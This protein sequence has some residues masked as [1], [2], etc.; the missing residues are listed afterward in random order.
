MLMS[1]ANAE[2]ASSMDSGRC[3]K[4]RSFLVSIIC[5]RLVLSVALPNELGAGVA[6]EPED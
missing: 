4:E 3:R 6:T 2:N 5:S 1:G